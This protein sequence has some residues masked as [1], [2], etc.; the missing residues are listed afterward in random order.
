MPDPVLASLFLKTGHDHEPA[1]VASLRGWYMRALDVCLARRAPVLT[2]AVVVI[3]MG[4]AVASALG[5]EFLPRLD[6]GDISISAVR[7]ASVGISEVAASTG[8]IE[9]VLRKLPEV[10]RLLPRTEDPATSGG[11]NRS[12]QS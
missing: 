7:P 6:E 5:G 9:R 3:A 11:C 8:R 1:F 4:G 10:L 2:G 12:R